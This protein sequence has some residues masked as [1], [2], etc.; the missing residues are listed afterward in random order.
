[1]NVKK[2]LLLIS[3]VIL[4][5]FAFAGCGTK[6]LNL[7]DYITYEFEGYNGYGEANIYFDRDA[8]EEDCVKIKIKNE[9][10]RG[11]YSNAADYYQDFCIAYSVDI[12]E[13]LENGDIVTV[14]WNCDPILARENTSGELVCKDMEIEVEGLEFVSYFDIFEGVSIEYG[15]AFPSAT[16]SVI[17]EGNDEF[18]FSIRRKGDYLPYLTI[19][20]IYEGEV[21][22]IEADMED[23]T[24]EETIDKYGGLPESMTKE[25]TIP[26][27]ASYAQKLSDLSK[28]QMAELESKANVI[29]A[30]KQQEL[31]EQPDYCEV[32]LIEKAVGDLDEQTAKLQLDKA[33]KVYFIYELTYPGENGFS[34][35]TYVIIEDVI[36]NLD[37]TMQYNQEEILY[38]SAKTGFFGFVTGEGFW[39]DEKLHLGFKTIEELREQIEYHNSLIVWD[40]EVQ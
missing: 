5:C 1:M 11:W 38:P 26:A 10:L 15:G 18:S 40:I 14:T 36:I 20:N 7:N 19:A 21:L 31:Y 22:T 27:M 33:G 8:F 17:Y 9:R 29:L 16:A 23:L 2:I 25:F 39:E 34:Y 30:E 28:D 3:M 12:P 13:D 24:L 35:Y 6:K 37:G 32:K 4:S